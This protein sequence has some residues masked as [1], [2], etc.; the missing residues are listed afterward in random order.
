MFW[1]HG[2]SDLPGCW[3][4]ALRNRLGYM[5]SWQHTV[6]MVEREKQQLRFLLLKSVCPWQPLSPVVGVRVLLGC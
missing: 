1:R 2:C 4:L 6:D 5:G 3:P